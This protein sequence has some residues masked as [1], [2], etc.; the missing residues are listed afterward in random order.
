[1]KIS[2]IVRGVLNA[3]GGWNDKVRSAARERHDHRAN[4]EACFAN[5]AHP[6]LLAAQAETLSANVL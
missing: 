3:V 2:S 6:Q 4:S 5:A 1:L